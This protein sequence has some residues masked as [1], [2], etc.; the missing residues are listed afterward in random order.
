MK[1]M[2]KDPLIKHERTVEVYS[3]APPDKKEKRPD[4]TSKH[5]YWKVLRTARLRNPLKSDPTYPLCNQEPNDLQ[6]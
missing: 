4:S 6:H 1:H 3:T 2:V 5:Q